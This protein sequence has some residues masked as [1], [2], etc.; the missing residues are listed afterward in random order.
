MKSA[1]N[2][3]TCLCQ[4]ALE[5]GSECE[6]ALERNEL[7]LLQRHIH[8]CLTQSESLDGT[9]PD[10]T[11][12]IMVAWMRANAH[13]LRP[14]LLT[15]CNGARSLCLDLIMTRH[16]CM[17]FSQWPSMQQHKLALTAVCVQERRSAPKL[18]IAL[19]ANQSLSCLGA[20]CSRQRQLRLT[21]G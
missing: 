8:S 2:G 6:A 7:A 18:R 19:S 17:L 20:L 16:T 14:E 4:P 9:G 5:A 15:L 3:S 11:T 12:A 1:C 21:L 10:G 13:S